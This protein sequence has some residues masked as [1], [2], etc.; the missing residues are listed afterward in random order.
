MITIPKELY[1]K[2]VISLIKNLIS[3]DDAK[4]FDAL[5]ESNKDKLIALGMKA[6]NYDVEII[7]GQETNRLLANFYSSYDRDDE[8]ELTA[9]IHE[10]IR[11]Y[12]S[13]FF[14]EMIDEEIQS[15]RK[16]ELIDSGRKPF[17]D[18]INGEIRWI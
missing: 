16:N 10:N 14:N 7:L 5:D 11:E 15:R 6:L 1:N 9:S 4:D 8:I 13:P 2:E 12:F 17:V 18:R 3:F